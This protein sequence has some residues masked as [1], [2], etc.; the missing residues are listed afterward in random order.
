MCGLELIFLWSGGVLGLP[1]VLF[2]SFSSMSIFLDF[3]LGLTGVFGGL[4]V[5]TWSGGD[6][7]GFW[8]IL[9]LFCLGCGASVGSARVS[10]FP[11][12]L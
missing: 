12:M 8:S 3:V 2:L 9:G 7:S 4:L 6:D 1:M 5:K 11:W 10:E